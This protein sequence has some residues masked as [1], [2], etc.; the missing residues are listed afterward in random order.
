MSDKLGFGIASWRYRLWIRFFAPTAI[1]INAGTYK[2]TTATTISGFLMTTMRTPLYVDQTITI[3]PGWS[4]YDIDTYLA[5]K[6]IGSTGD[7]LETSRINFTKYQNEFPF[8]SGASTLEGFLYP[9]TYR[10]RQDAS[11]DDAIRVM[12][13]EF[14][15]KIGSM[16]AAF[17]NK[18]AYQTLI[19]AS[20]VEREERSTANQP[21][22]AGILSKRVTQ[23]IAM[24][25]DATVCYG[26]AKTQK[27]CT[28]SFI[29]S[30]IQDKHPYNTRNI[31]GYPP[32]PIANVP[33]SAWNA[34][35]N[36]EASPYYYY[37][38]GT[39]GVIHY[40]RTNEEHIANKIQYL[41]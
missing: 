38:H 37:L 11:T 17:N 2:A 20:I 40:G 34:A 31:Q 33:L 22:V 29:G 13:R 26:Y 36:P 5:N 1:A 35:L 16:Y 8:L 9:D 21:I 7:F 32:T 39:D 19:L 3:L 24:G 28:P 25:A 15:K 23:G 12:L 6:G 14:N 4:S 41:Q 27:Q 10:L 18:K 30:I